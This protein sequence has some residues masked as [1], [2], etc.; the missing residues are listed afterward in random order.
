MQEED[1]EEEA[2]TNPLDNRYIF[3]LKGK[4]VYSF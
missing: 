1:R 2:P 4:T 3:F